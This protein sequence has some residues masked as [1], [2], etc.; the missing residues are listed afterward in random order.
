MALPVPVSELPF[1]TPGHPVEWTID[2]FREG[3]V[4]P[5]DKPKGWSS[6]DVVRFVRNRVPVRKVGHAGTLDPMATGLL[7]LCCGRA[8]RS[9]EQFQSYRKRYL[10]TI[11][12]G[13]ETAS[14][15]AET[16]GERTAP[17]D[18]LTAEAIQNKID[19]DFLGE[20]M[21]QPPIFSALKREGVRNYKRARS[22]D[23]TR[24]EPRLVELYEATL[25]RFELPEIEIDLVCGKGFYVRSLAHDLA[26]SLASLGHLTSLRRTETGSVHIR[27]AW[28]PSELNEWIGESGR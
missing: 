3:V 18:H 13:E 15:D 26:I 20:Q 22:G 2:R 14:Y 10:A 8:T 7:I 27:D 25:T 1:H 6:F 16:V 9:I 19:S 28:T 12:L 4:I 23:R 21:Q 17:V 5:M 11:R 24:P